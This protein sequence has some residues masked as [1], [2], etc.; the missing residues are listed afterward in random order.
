[1]RKIIIIWLLKKMNVGHG[2]RGLA[3]WPAEWV[4]GHV[5]HKSISPAS[6]MELGYFF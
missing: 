3:C 4:L 6:V 5:K 2:S 1:M